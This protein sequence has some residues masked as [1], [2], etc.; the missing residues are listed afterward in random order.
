MTLTQSFSHA[1]LLIGSVIL[2]N[3]S[4]ECIGS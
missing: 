4:G 1:R 2:M 3:Q